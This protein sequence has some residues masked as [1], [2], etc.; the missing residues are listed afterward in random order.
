LELFKL[1][2]GFAFKLKAKFKKLLDLRCYK[3]PFKD[4][5]RI[6]DML[7]VRRLVAKK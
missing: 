5:R 4:A 1:S 3:N 7:N 2:L 6:W